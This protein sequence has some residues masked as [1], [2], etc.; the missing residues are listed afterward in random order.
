MTTGKA[1]IGMLAGLAAG[2]VIGM[3]L[4]PP[5]SGRLRKIISRK[6]EDLADAI[7]DKIDEKFEELLKNVSGRVKKT[8]ARDEVSSDNPEV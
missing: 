6:S 4:A 5:K 2:T 8:K 1:L 7:N 3:I